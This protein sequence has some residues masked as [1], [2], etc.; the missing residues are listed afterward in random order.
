M[1]EHEQ[2][3]RFGVFDDRNPMLRGFSQAMM[4]GES[5]PRFNRS[6]ELDTTEGSNILLSFSD[7]TPTIV[8]KRVGEG[9]GLLINAS[10][11]S[12]GWTNLPLN[13]IF[14]PLVQRLIAYAVH[15]GQDLEIVVGG[16]TDLVFTRARSV[17]VSST[18]DGDLQPIL[19]P[20]GEEGMARFDLTSAPGIYRAVEASGSSPPV[21]VAVNVSPE[22]SDLTGITE[23]SAREMLGNNAMI[24][25]ST[26]RLGNRVSN[27]RR[28]RE[29]WGWLLALTLALMVVETILS[30]V[31]TDKQ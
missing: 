16:Q 22:E 25:D 24:L 7:G 6:Y 12:L 10:S 8:E 18:T 19:L 27:L 1:R 3:I 9:L 4:S 2:P 31:S 21:Y 13:P 5:S 28:G 30:N 26:S 29:I 15:P 20:V 14:L 23:E 11:W 17:E